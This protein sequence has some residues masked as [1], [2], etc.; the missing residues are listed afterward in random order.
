MQKATDLRTALALTAALSAPAMAGDWTNNGGNASRNGMSDEVGPL[1]ADVLWS[2]GR[3]TI[4]SWQPMIVGSRVFAV[5]QSGFPPGSEP[6]GSPVVC[7]DLDTGAELWIRHVPYVSGDWTTWILGATNGLVYASRSGNGASVSQVVYALD[8]ATGATVWTS[9]D[10][11]DSGP[12]DGVV[13]APNGDPI[14]GNQAS[15]IRLSA[16]D[17][18]TVWSVPRICNVTSSCGVAL[19]GNGVYVVEPIPG[20]QAVRKLDA[21]TGASQYAS[22]PMA[23]FTVQNTP[24]VGPDGTV[25]LSRTQNNDAVDFLYAFEDTGA[26]LVEKWHEEAGW[27]TTSEFACAPDA[28]VVMLDRDFF[29][30]RL[31]SSTGA[32]LAVSSVPI[33]TPGGSRSPHLAVDASGKVWA[34]NGEFAAGELFAFDPD[35]AL[36][37]S[38]PVTNVN[39]GGPALGSDGTLVVAGLSSLTAYRSACQ[40]PASATLRNAGPNPASL[41][42]ELPVIGSAWTTSV[43]V[44]T[45]GHD[46][47][48]LFAADTPLD[49]TLAGG[50]HLLCGGAIL[51]TLVQPGPQ[52]VFTMML[53]N[54]V[55]LCG[56]AGC[57]QAVHFGGTTPFALSN[58]ADLVLGG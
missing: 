52:A 29:L 50:Q 16:A 15:V 24:F 35:L 17:G 38:V 44:A 3:P 36:R 31:D 4:I 45:S 53:P 48:I 12:Y 58:A 19:F 7:M 11:I 8:Q 51:F 5:R 9:A 33:S 40:V 20:G 41:E 26:A 34:S 1:A 27:S 32:T 54:N 22:T 10:P 18:S 49:L 46:F 28:S 23:G 55:A 6:N 57:L 37:W 21:S 39:Q 43:N 2:A 30:R 42:T 47:A 56:R 13:F 25:Y 14:V